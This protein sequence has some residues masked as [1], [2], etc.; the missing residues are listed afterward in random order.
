MQLY[1]RV[2]VPTESQSKEVSLAHVS[3]E[4]K[5]FLP[6]VLSL[7]K[8]LPF[9]KK[10]CFQFIWSTFNFV[11]LQPTLIYRIYYSKILRPYVTRFVK[12]GLEK[13]EE[14]L[15][16]LINPLRFIAV[17]AS[18]RNLTFL[19]NAQKIQTEQIVCTPEMQFPTIFLH[20]FQALYVFKYKSSL[21][22]ITFL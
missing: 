18:L 7:K 21:K 9:Q 3:K 4:C 1:S 17:S 14:I 16:I 11:T 15:A 13:L 5:L 19:S 22:R 10:L 2:Q 6:T 8:Y 20:F 12:V